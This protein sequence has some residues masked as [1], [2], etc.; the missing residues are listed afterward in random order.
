ME[1]INPAVGV[2]TA[3]FLALVTLSLAYRFGYFAKPHHSRPPLIVPLRQFIGAFIVFL[4]IQLFGIPLI[5]YAWLKTI[6]KH[7]QLTSVVQGWFNLGAILTVGA[8]LAIYTKI[9]RKGQPSFFRTDSFFKDIGLGAVTWLISYPLVLFVAQ[10]LEYLFNLPMVEQVAVQQIRRAME[11]PFLFTTIILAV[12]VIVPIIEE[13][14]FRGYMF[15][16]LRSK[17][18]FA[19]SAFVSSA[20]FALFHFSAT[21]G[22]GN[23]NIIVP[24]FVLALFLAYLYEKRQSLWAPIGLHMIFNT[25]SIIMIIS[26][27]A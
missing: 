16:Y 7:S 8:A 4:A 19:K 10:S 25:I 12:C 17:M 23:V 9:V 18:S 1:P 26:G 24:L 6:G 2:L 11:N 13:T 20:I 27:L 15:T 3:F 21:Q 22:L 5:A 14:L